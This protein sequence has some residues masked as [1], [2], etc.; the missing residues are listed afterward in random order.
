MTITA[1][2]SLSSQVNAY[3]LGY[4]CQYQRGYLYSVDNTTS[5]TGNIRGKVATTTD[6]T[7][8]WS[9]V[10]FDIPSIK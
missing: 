6:Q 4:G 3:I 2:G 10:S 1:D 7:A 9:A 5:N 8:F